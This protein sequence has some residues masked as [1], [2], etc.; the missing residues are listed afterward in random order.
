MSSTRQRGEHV[1]TIA[2]IGCGAFAEVYYLPALVRFPGV[3]EKLILVDSNGARAQHLA[4]RFGIH[5]CVDDYRAIL[6]EVDAAIVA[7]PHHLHYPISMDFLQHSAHVLCEKPL[8][9]KAS[10][11]REMVAEA[12]RAGVTLSAN[13]TQRLFPSS[14]KVKELLAGGALGKL[15]SIHYSWGSLYTWPT[16]S[17]FYFNARLSPR[18]VLLDRGPHAVDLICWWLGDRP[19]VVSCQHDSFGGAEAVA[20]VELSHGDCAITIALSWLNE[21]PNEY[22]IRGERGEIRNGIEDWWRIPIALPSGKVHKIK[23]AH[24]EQDYFDFGRRLIANF[25]NVIRAGDKPLI[26]AGDVIPSVEVI[27]ACYRTATRF[28]MPWYE[29]LGTLWSPASA[30]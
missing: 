4:S 28:A 13:Y 24:D 15:A 20:Q 19:A 10:E 11:A 3:A 7:A 30:R 25:L 21:L 2:L 16:A 5:R 8:A 18:G 22:V 6:G 23:L 29:N 9:E 17:G 27:E 1:P 12:E 14:V 26:P